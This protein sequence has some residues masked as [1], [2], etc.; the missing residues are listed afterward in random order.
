MKTFRFLLF[1]FIFIIINIR[2]KE[3]N[4]TL[5]AHGINLAVI[6]TKESFIAF[7]VSIVKTL[8]T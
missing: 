8:A 1:L 5:L 3:L 4:G 2:T 7:F 6:A